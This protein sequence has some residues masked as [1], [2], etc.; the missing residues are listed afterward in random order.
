MH[1]S[2]VVEF[3]SQPVIKS[4]M[5]SQAFRPCQRSRPAVLVAQENPV[6]RKPAVSVQ[7]EPVAAA[8]RCS[9]ELCYSSSLERLFPAAS[10]AANAF[11][12]RPLHH[13]TLFLSL[14]ACG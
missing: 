2:C 9:Q 4:G 11:G 13:V 3:L 10:L 5:F 14:E 12:R 1:L 8:G 7:Q 6:M